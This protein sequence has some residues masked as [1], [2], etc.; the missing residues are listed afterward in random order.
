MRRFELT[1]GTSNKFWQIDVQD[2]TY[3]VT[4]GKKGSNGQTQIKRFSDAATATAEAEKVIAEKTKKGYV[5][6]G[7]AAPTPAPAP[8]PNAAPA[9]APTPTPAPA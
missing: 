6:I 7:E 3:K 8:T 9:L 2:T 1:E 4:F 5:E